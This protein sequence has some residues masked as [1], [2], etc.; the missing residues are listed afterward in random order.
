L[1]TDLRGDLDGYQNSLFKEDAA[2]EEAVAS[3]MFSNQIIEWEKEHP[4][5]DETTQ[6]TQ[7]SDELTSFKTGG[8]ER[9]QEKF[10]PFGEVSSYPEDPNNITLY[11]AS[12]DPRYISTQTGMISVEPGSLLDLYNQS[13]QISSPQEKEPFPGHKARSKSL[14][15]SKSELHQPHISPS[16]SERSDNEGDSNDAEFQ[17]THSNSE[18]SPTLK[19]KRN[20]H[21]PG[22]NRHTGELTLIG[23]YPPMQL[24]LPRQ[25]GCQHCWAPD[26][27]RNSF[28]WATRNG[29]K[30]HLSNVCLGNPDSVKSI[31]LRRAKELGTTVDTVPKKPA[32]SK[33]C[34]CG[35]YFRSENGYRMHR[36]QNETTKN[37][38][39][40]QRGSKNYRVKTPKKVE[41]QPVTFDV[42][43]TGSL[44][45]NGAM[46]LE[47]LQSITPYL[48][49]NNW[50]MYQGGGIAGIPGVNE[51]AGTPDVHLEERA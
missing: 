19:P 12:G 4:W 20:G 23:R 1:A 41:A 35:V 51:N 47:M 5:G 10:T 28:R 26:P 16:S 6:L 25:Y 7:I 48:A 38:R 42:N 2:F 11:E 8:D 17:P 49:E 30:Y 34:E 18:C 13:A 45:W 44:G 15:T 31:K 50:G 43:M 27:E 24:D 39:C 3:Q 46:T 37:G 33:V 22:I 14:S 36:M 40:M 21:T 29:Y 9:T 32:F